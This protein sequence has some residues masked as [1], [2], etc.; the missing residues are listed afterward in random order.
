MASTAAAK[1]YDTNGGKL[2]YS[3]CA[4]A[5]F[6]KRQFPPAL[7]P[8]LC[9]FGGC[10]PAS[11]QFIWRKIRNAAPSSCIA[12]V[13]FGDNSANFA[14]DCQPDELT[15]F[16]ALSTKSRLLSSV[17][18]TVVRGKMPVRLVMYRG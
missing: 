18:L 6:A 3:R 12:A 14:I 16:S 17:Q 9:Q 11:R 10:Y 13:H 2:A 7:S 15:I 5:N 4:I 8:S 1:G